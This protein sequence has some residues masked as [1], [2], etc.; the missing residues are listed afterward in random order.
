MAGMTPEDLYDL[1]W[2]L[3]ARLSPDGATLAYVVCEIDRTTNEYVSAIWTMPLDGSREAR[4][5]TSGSKRDLDPRWAPDGRVIAFTSNRDGEQAQLYVIDAHGGEAAKLTALAEDVEEIAWSPDGRTIAFS[6]R[7]R[8]PAYDE[9]DER[10][11]APRRFRRLQFKLDDVGWTG[12]RRQHLFT[13][14]TDGSESPRQLTDGDFEDATPAWSPDGARI[15]FVSNRDDDWDLST[16]RDVYVIESAGGEPK[17]VTDG[18]GIADLPQWSPD[19]SL[20]AFQLTPGD[21]DE[22]RH[23][24]IAVV[25]PSSRIVTTLTDALD[26][27]C[28]PYPAIRPPQWTSAGRLAFG[29]ED[30]GNTHLYEVGIA[31]RSVERI[32]GGERSITGWD[33]AAG[34]LVYLASTPTGL[35]EAFT[36]DRRLTHVQAAF[37]E[38]RSIV[39][40]ERFT[41]VS[42]D[43][44]EVDAWIMRPAGF[45]EGR[46]YPVLLNIH[47][48]PFAQYGNRFFD[49][50][51]VQAGAGY[52]VLYSNPRGSSGYSEEWGRAIRGPG[53]EGPGW[54]TVDYDDVIAVVDTALERYDF[55][56]PDRLG[57]LGG[58]YGGYLTSWIVAH[59][60]RFKAA[61][62][63]RAVNDWPSMH[64][65]SDAGWMFKGYVGS[66]LFEDAEAW[67]AMSPTTHATRIDTPLLIMHSENDLRC[68]IEQ[69]EQLFTTLRLLKKDVELVRWPGEGHELTRSGSPVHRVARFQIILEWFDRYLAERPER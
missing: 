30:A 62:S 67:R 5:L 22:P 36:G 28:G 65:S 14:A 40:A 58:S 25:D 12:D 31:D 61:C 33:F 17:P 52:V 55:C 45:V 23:A 27:N 32:V 7:V 63:E 9:T 47:G 57:V 35:P 54:G 69:A 46:R 8:D 20:I 10:R 37:T 64:G 51:Q 1:R 2:V 41:A 53:R 43:G 56:D 29:V 26:R 4:Q 18:E 34:K 39:D 68:N 42:P 11:R 44:A 60:H 50:F 21:F 38:S 6:S 49:E 3:D 15:A 13:I 24:R 59:N 48:G 66:F 16:V 19:G